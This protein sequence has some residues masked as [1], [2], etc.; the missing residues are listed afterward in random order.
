MGMIQAPT[1]L[2][3]IDAGYNIAET[4]L[5]DGVNDYI[6]SSSASGWGLG[7]GAGRDGVFAWAMQRHSRGTD[8]YL[9]ERGVNSSNRSQIL[10]DN[11]DRLKF[12]HVQGDVVEWEVVTSARLRDFGGWYLVELH[13][14]M[15]NP[16]A[17][18]AAYFVINGARQTSYD[19]FTTD[20][21]THN[22]SYFETDH[23]TYNGTIGRSSIFGSGYFKGRL[24]Q[25]QVLD[26]ISAP[27]LGEEVDGHY[28]PIEYKGAYGS[29]GIL[30]QGQISD[31]SGNS[32]AL[33]NNGVTVGEKA[34][35]TNKASNDN[36]NYLTFNDANR[37]GFTYTEGNLRADGPSGQSSTTGTLPFVVGVGQGGIIY[38][39]HES[40]LT[41]GDI[42]VGFGRN[43]RSNQTNFWGDDNG[44]GYYQGAGSILHRRH[45]C[46]FIPDSRY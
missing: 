44:W 33:T 18:D 36:G 5:L 39:E 26:G 35:P 43:V 34:S 45:I 1:F 20:V 3:P 6:T 41:N 32:I 15:N 4:L 10:I 14:D 19:T 31:I 24:T 40:T 13:L 22:Q 17:A 46:S 42:V 23:T 8:Q 27:I 28:K 21:T 25:I 11:N 9:F 12:V 37:Q 7:D 30:V 29:A 2:S 38:F 16:T